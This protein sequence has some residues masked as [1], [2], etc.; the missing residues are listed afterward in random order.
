MIRTR[1]I[2]TASE[3]TL[4]G[5]RGR[6]YGSQFSR[7]GIDGG[8]AMSL[9]VMKNFINEEREAKVLPEV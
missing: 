6:A 4:G 3:T 5:S 2:A 7:S 8:E 9:Q 1:W